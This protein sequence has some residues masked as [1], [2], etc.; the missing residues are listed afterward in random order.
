MADN[1]T[2]GRAPAN[3]GHIVSV[4]A[5]ELHEMMD[6]AGKTMD[7]LENDIPQLQRKIDHELAEGEEG[8]VG[9]IQQMAEVRNSLAEVRG[10][11]TNVQEEMRTVDDNTD[12]DDKMWKAIED[13]RNPNGGFHTRTY[14]ALG[15]VFE[16]SYNAY[17]KHKY[18]QEVEGYTRAADQ[19]STTDNIGGILV[20]TATWDNVVYVMGE[21]SYLRAFA[22]KINMPTDDVKVPAH[23]EGVPTIQVQG[24]QGSEVTHSVLT[25]QTTVTM[26]AQTLIGLNVIPNQLVQDAIGSWSTFWARVFTDA[27]ALKENKGFFSEDPADTNGAF[28]GVVQEIAAASGDL[29]NIVQ[30][31]DSAG[32]DDFS[33]VAFDDINALLFANHE[34]ARDGS[35]FVSSNAVARYVHGITDDNSQPIFS[36]QWQGFNVA[37]GPTPNSAGPRAAGLMNHPYYIT[38]AMPSSNAADQAFM[39][40]GNPAFTF[41]GERA[42]MAIE[43]SKESQF[44]MYNTVM[45]VA[46]R[47]GVKTVATDPWAYLK[48]RA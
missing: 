24:T 22:N 48:T 25:F 21:K 36:S 18:T 6:A 30:L 4:E 40:F 31:A 16:D 12:R 42:P 33:T 26:T 9:L 27:M 11:V 7:A 32:S 43:F 14:Q 44:E 8:D 47:I 41:W 3:A 1:T 35:I 15:K 20:P 28:S 19:S 38:S 34:N 10:I 46:E 37:G 5:S 45:R 13:L 39:L 23:T 2:R 29:Q 17:N